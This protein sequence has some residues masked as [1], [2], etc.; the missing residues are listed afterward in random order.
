M[1]Y[2]NCTMDPRSISELRIKNKE[3]EKN[4]LIK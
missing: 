4:K 1:T 3:A 2:M